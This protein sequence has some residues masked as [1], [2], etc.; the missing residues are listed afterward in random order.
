MSLRPFEYLI[1]LERE[2]HFGRAADSCHLTQSALSA[3]IKRLEADF[4]VPIVRRGQRYEGL[5]AEG[6]QI[7]SW[8]QR[9]LAER[10]ALDQRLRDGGD[11]LTGVLRLG[12]I[13]TAVPVVPRL[14]NQ[15]GDAH[16]ELRFQIRTLSAPRLLAE[17]DA[18]AIDVGLTY[19]EPGLTGV[20]A[21][22]LYEERY[23]LL[24]PDGVG[25]GDSDRRGAES[26]D[27]TRATWQEV[28]DQRLVSLNDEMQHRRLIDAALREVGTRARVMVETDSVAALYD[29]LA[30]TRLSSV[31][32]HT[33]MAARGLPEGYR[34]RELPP[35]PGRAQPPTV[36]LILA[37]SGPEPRAVRALIDVASALDLDRV[38]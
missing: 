6:R 24:T 15:L 18:F 3:A 31:V 21:L 29:H 35:I 30:G 11:G 4:G 12:V 8:A 20:R 16:P 13:P 5:T 28:G 36:G 37:A 17:I 9:T 19:L 7:L 38:T 10:A 32:P 25:P 1:A 34:A 22:P 23:L 14:T 27:A 26:F 2:Q 33:W